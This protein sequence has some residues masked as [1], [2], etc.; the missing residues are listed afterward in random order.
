MRLLKTILVG[1]F[2][3]PQFAFAAFTVPLSATTTTGTILAFPT[4]VNGILPKL[5]SPYFIAT[6]TTASILPNAS[7]TA[8]SATVFCFTGDI[9]RT[10]WPSG[11]GTSG[12]ATTSFSATWPV[13]LSTSASTIN[14]GFNGLSTSSPITAGAAVLYAT[15]VNTVASAATTTASCSGS[16]SCTSFSIL[17]SS[18]VTIAGSGAA[19]PFT[20]NGTGVFWNQISVSTTTQIHFGATGVSLS[21]SSTSQFD[22]AS[23]TALT[24]GNLF[25]TNLT[26]T[27]PLTTANGGTGRSNPGGT[28]AGA[29]LEFDGTN[30]TSVISAGAQY[31]TVQSTAAG[32][33]FTTDAVH[34]DQSGAVTGNLP[35]NRGGTNAA[36]F[37]TSGNGVYYNGSALL[38]APLTS[39][40]TYPY[41]S[42]TS[43]TANNLF[44][45]NASSTS[46]FSLYNYASSAFF[47]ATGSTTIDFAGRL[48]IGSSTPSFA[49]TVAT[50]TAV[51][52]EGKIFATS[53]SKTIDW[54]NCNST[55]G[56][57]NQQ[58]FQ[59]GTA[60]VAI[61][62]NNASTAGMT[63]RF[64]WCNSGSS[65]GALTFNVPGL[66][67]SG[68]TVPTQTTTANKCDVYSFIV[69]NAS[70]SNTATTT[71]IFGA[72]TPNF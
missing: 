59:T 9:C 72:Q 22:Y 61:G 16:V 11:G 55:A 4:A 70:S 23:S 37:T 53:T 7:S 39:A 12:T 67:W 19:Y 13:T 51:L 68:G 58:L 38:T 40:V 33:G 8:I 14:Y 60:A 25:A 43:A 20:P 64:I 46:Y 5:A 30:G 35:L 27:N 45:T 28:S 65:A 63:M 29:L 62:F 17:G 31:T 41:A 2:L 66:L 44:S 57:C 26:L 34:L 36:S 49:F 15:G 48:A 18:P 3:V 6:S 69:T 52:T 1:L 71:V 47:G 21:A 42:S 50:G 56:G 24:A 54:R 32:S 10:T